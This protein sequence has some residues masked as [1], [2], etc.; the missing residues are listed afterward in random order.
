MA[1]INLD[2][3]RWEP[4]AANEAAKATPPAFAEREATLTPIQSAPETQTQALPTQQ[5]PAA[6]AVLDSSD[7]QLMAAL[8]ENPDALAAQL[9]EI[10]PEA[11][12]DEL[13]AITPAEITPPAQG[14]AYN[15]LKNFEAKAFAQDP[16]IANI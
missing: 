13:E 1:R 9:N 10:A 8:E 16:Q 7:D 2:Q 12:R 11:V 5:T 14:A 15:P 6:Q 4:I 3:N